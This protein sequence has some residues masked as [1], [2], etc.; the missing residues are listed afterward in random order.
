MLIYSSS[1]KK[2]LCVKLGKEITKPK[3]LDTSIDHEFYWSNNIVPTINRKYVELRSNF[4]MEVKQV[5]LD[6]FKDVV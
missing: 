4:I 3:E 1:H 2:S 6:K 5:Y